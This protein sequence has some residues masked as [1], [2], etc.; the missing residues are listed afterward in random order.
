LAK[1]ILW[2]WLYY[3]KQYI[4]SMQF[5]SKIPILFFIEIGKK[6]IKFIEKYKRP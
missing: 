2:K 1:L 3:P 6:I 5:D 4:D